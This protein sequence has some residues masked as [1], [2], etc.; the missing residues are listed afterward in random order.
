MPIPGNLITTAMA[1]MPHTDAERAL[2]QALSL[3]EKTV[4]K[5]FAVVQKLSNTL[6]TKYNM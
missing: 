1:V 5:A 3:K 2:E 4:E 6:R